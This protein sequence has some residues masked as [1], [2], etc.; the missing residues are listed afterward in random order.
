MKRCPQCQQTFL[1]E[2]LYCLSDGTLL[3]PVFDA[4]EETTVITTSP[5]TP[6]SSQPVRQGV[7][8]MFAYLSTAL[9]ALVVGGAVVLWVKSDS[10]V[11]PYA[12]N[13]VALTNSNAIEL[14]PNKNQDLLSQQKA[15]LQNEQESLEKEKQKLA[16]ERKKLEAQKNKSNEPMI[17]NQT[18][19]QNYPTARIKFRRGSVEETIS[20]NIGSERSF[21]LNT[22]SGQYLSASV[23]SGNDCVVFANGSTNTSNTTSKGDSYLRLK[24]NCGGGTNFN[25][26]VYVR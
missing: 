22:L 10:N 8:S 17:Y 26:T 23:S 20:G 12:K 1:D 21:V 13:E 18:S 5:F 7:S 2:N 14:S 16:D 6:Q 3:V 25:L 24:N 9:L 4:P 15:N 19:P 11:S